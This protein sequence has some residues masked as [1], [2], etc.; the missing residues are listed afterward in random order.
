MTALLADPIARQH[1]IGP[2]HPEQIARWDAAVKGLGGHPLTPIAPRAAT[3][4]E[5]A[6]CHAPGYIRSA[7]RDV[8]SGLSYLTTGDTDICPASFNVALHASGLCLNAVDL[9]M[10]GEAGN[11]F[12]IVRPPGHHATPDRGMG[13]CLFNNVAI[14]ARYAQRRYGVERVL[15]AGTR[16]VTDVYLLGLAA[17]HKGTVVSFD[18]S[19]AW[20][21]VRGGS[22]RLVQRPG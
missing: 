19:L 9:V 21:G 6:L 1:D 8:K 17:R 2:G 13:F 10:R 18:R 20:Q 15:I 11:A 7:E 4:D 3:F 12:C 14:A 22:A 16:Q 5:V